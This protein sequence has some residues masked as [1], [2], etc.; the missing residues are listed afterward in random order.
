LTFTVLWGPVLTVMGLIFYAS[1]LSDPGAPANVSDKAAHF[2][3]YGALGGTLIRALAGGRSA[4]MTAMRIL[5]ATVLATLYGV[6]DEI[7]QMFVPHRTPDW[8]DVCAD[9]FG[10]MTGAVV[11]GLAAKLLSRTRWHGRSWRT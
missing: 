1:S 6:S 8:Q 5:A 11:V 3:V 7:H 10:A 2:L 9:A 4:R